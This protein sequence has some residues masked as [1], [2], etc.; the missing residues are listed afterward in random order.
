MIA[1]KIHDHQLSFNY[2][3]SL[4]TPEPVFSNQLG[5]EGG[6]AHRTSWSIK[7]SGEE[8]MDIVECA[9]KSGVKS[10]YPEPKW[11]GYWSYPIL[12]PMNETI[13]ITCTDSELYK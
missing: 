11:V 5:W 2:D 9:Q 3:S 8:F 7:C 10:F 12:D 6:T 1:F 4:V 13:E